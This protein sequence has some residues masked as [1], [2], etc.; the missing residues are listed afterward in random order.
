MT[1]FHHLRYGMWNYYKMSKRNQ[2][3]YLSANADIELLV[4]LYRCFQEIWKLVQ[5][6]RNQ[7]L[8]FDN[9]QNLRLEFFRIAKKLADE[10]WS[11]LNPFFMDLEHSNTTRS[12]I[13]V[14][15]SFQSLGN[16]PEKKLRGSERKPEHY[17]L[18]M[19]NFSLP[20]TNCPNI[21]DIPGVV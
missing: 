14:D 18:Q 16:T 9:S 12:C 7:H 1:S 5:S 10:P 6:S 21:S 13:S 20:T 3:S 15:I 2:V 4:L 19:S 11:P 17:Q 8:V